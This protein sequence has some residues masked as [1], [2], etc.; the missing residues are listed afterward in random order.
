VRKENYWPFKKETLKI[1]G[2]EV[3]NGRPCKDKW[4]KY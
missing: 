4:E 1:V 2:E 3:R